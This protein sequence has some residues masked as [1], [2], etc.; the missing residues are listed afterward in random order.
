MADARVHPAQ[1]RPPRLAPTGL[2]VVRAL[3]FVLVAEH[4][5]SLF[6]PPY[7][8]GVPQA[9]HLSFGLLYAWLAVKLLDGRPWTRVL[10][11]VLLAV[12]FVGRI[13]VF[14]LI[15]NPWIRLLLIVGAVLTIAVVWLLWIVRPVRVFFR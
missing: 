4:A 6:T 5:F 2:V 10:V 14:A 1:D 3:L 13:V 15:D 8:I 9:F 12:Q 7:G 11:T